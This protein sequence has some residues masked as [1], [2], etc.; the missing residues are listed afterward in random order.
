MFTL[1]ILVLKVF[2]RLVGFMLGLIKQHQPLLL[3]GPGCSLTLCE[4]ISRFGG[5]HVLLVTDKI[6]LGLGLLDPIRNKLLDL[7]LKITLFS[8]VEPDPGFSIVRQGVSLGKRQGCDAILAVGGGSVIDV[9]KVLSAAIGIDADVKTLKG[10]MKVKAPVIPLYVAP[11]TSGTGSE[12]SIGAVITDEV[13]HKK[14]GVAS[15][16]LCP[17]VAA[18]DPELMVGMPP[19]ITA[20]TGLDALTH[21]IEAFISRNA[22]ADSDRFSLVAIKLIFSN[23]ETAY[24]K[25]S[26]LD[27]RQS[28]A[29]AAT[30]AGL[31]FTRV[32]VGYVH[33]ISHALG[34][35]YGVPHGLANGIVLPH[36][37]RYSMSAVPERFAEMAI[38]AGLGE[39]GEA[40]LILGE[41]FVAAVQDLND[42]IGIPRTMDALRHEDMP[43]IASVALKE[44]HTVYAVPRYMSQDDC[45]TI[46]QQLKPVSAA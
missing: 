26:D 45:L 20:A 15:P 2:N 43:A 31:A 17:L 19:S 46:L 9:A 13:T 22:T 27:A 1:K 12:V 8:D 34:G 25:G 41:R 35:A 3:V 38:A 18:L 28:M 40:S 5:T 30:Y 39:P 36:I 11:T 16:L 23:L 4:D 37:L 42:S 21:A 14:D 29:I 10:F 7:G 6:L 44:A 32:L 33:A 24:N